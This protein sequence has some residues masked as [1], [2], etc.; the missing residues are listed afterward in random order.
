[1][2]NST[3]RKEGR[4]LRYKLAVSGSAAGT[5]VEAKEMAFEIGRQVVKQGA[6]LVTGATVGIPNEAARG[7]KSAGGFSVGLSP[8][9]SKKEHTKVYKLPL[10]YYDFIMFTGMDYAGRNFLMTRSADAVIVV[11]GRIGTLNEFTIAFEDDKPV[12]VLTGSGGISDEIDHILAVAKR[13]RGKVIFNK[14]PKELVKELIEILRAEEEKP[15][16]RGRAGR[17]TY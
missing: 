16:K 8:A 17:T 14:Q 2:T 12:G 6:V 13:G 4:Q 7:A 1:M 5:T 3:A 10:E 9:V 15:I 11:A